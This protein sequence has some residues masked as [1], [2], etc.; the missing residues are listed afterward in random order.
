M[1]RSRLDRGSGRRI[2]AQVMPLVVGLVVGACGD[3]GAGSS[4]AVPST[5]LPAGYALQLDRQNRDRADFVAT[6]DDGQLTVRTGPAG[7]LYRPEDVV[8]ADRY[9]LRGR[10]TE[11]GAPLGHREGFGLLIGGQHL[12]DTSQRY[13]YFLVRGDGRYLVKQRDGSSTHELSQGWQP[14][15][16]V[17]V[18]TTEGG[19]VTNEL[20]IAVDGRELRLSC[21][22]EPVA[23]LPVDR[24]DLD[25]HGVMGVRVNHN[26]RVRIEDFGLG[27]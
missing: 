12:G 21:N 8:E 14:S 17:R 24:L 1:K 11:V 5:H 16:A 3:R 9:T 26:L 6:V 4:D 18:P 15:D 22:G 23:D 2:A 13:V 27:P 20:A 10:F 19:E 25:I 7:I